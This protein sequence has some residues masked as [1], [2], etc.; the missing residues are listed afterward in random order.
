MNIPTGNVTFLF[1]DVEGSAK[2][3][4]ANPAAIQNALNRHREIFLRGIK[5]HN[6]FVFEKPGDAFCCA[7]ENT[8]DAVNASIDIQRDLANENWDD[9]KIQIKIGIHTGSAEWDGNKYSGYI[10]M[11]RT[12]RVMSAAYGGQVIVSDNAYE[13][14]KDKFESESKSLVSFRDLGV[15]R[16]KDVIQPIRL[17]Q[18]IS[19]GLREDFPPLKTLDA[20][21]NNLPVQ[22]TSFIGREKEMAAVK[23]L[24]SAARLLTLLGPGGTGKTRLSLQLAADMIDEFENG[25][26]IVEL[27]S[28]SDPALLVQAIADTLGLK[29]QTGMLLEKI[30]TDHL[31]SKE[32]LLVLD[33]CEHIINSCAELTEELLK[34]CP[35]L[36]IITTSRTVLRSEDETIYKVLPLDHPDPKKIKTHEELADYEAVR[37]FIERAVAVNPLFRI[38]ES[39]HLSIAQICYQL[40]GIP[41]A[42]ELAAVRVKVLSPENICKRLEDRFRLLTGGKRTALPRQQTLRAMLDW[43]YDLLSEKEKILWRRLSVFAGGWTAEAAEEICSDE[44]IEKS[45]VGSLLNDLAGKSII[46]LQGIDNKF[47]MLQTVMQYGGVLLSE[48]GEKDKFHNKHL[49]YYMNLCEGSIPEYS[50]P[51]AKLWL[52]RIEEFYPNVQSALGWSVEHELKEKGNRLAVSMGKFWELR[53]YYTEGRSWFDKLLTSKENLPPEI[54]AN[55]KSIAAIL[56]T[57]QGKYEVSDKFILEALEI[58]ERSGNKNR[59]ANSLNNLGLNAY[60]KGKYDE[61]KKHLNECLRIRK[62]SD[63]KIGICST[64]NSLGLVDLVEGD[65]VGAKKKFVDSLEIALELNDL[66][67]TGIAYSNLAQTYDFLGESEKTK[68]YFEKGLLI[69]REL[70]NKNGICVSLYNLGVIELN[71]QKYSDAKKLFEESK[72]IC[73]ETGYLLGELYALSGI[74]LVTFAE[75]DIFNAENIFKEVLRLQKGFIDLQCTAAGMMLIA[76]I[77]NND[78]KNELAAKLV[79]ACKTRYET[80]GA[81]FEKKMQDQYEIILKSV[82][83]AIGEERTAIAVEEGRTMGLDKAIEIAL[84]S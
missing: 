40:D 67:Y 43:S 76:E 3:S 35:G 81:F 72:A 5:S 30:L 79:S 37:L 64:L 32:L 77:K 84:N 58:Y 13:A 42:I 51:T 14:S 20:R 78:G 59:V 83:E 29:E 62:D 69:D 18:V 17:F 22:L 11:A 68:E 12:A 70:G 1:S 49:E 33:N 8:A 80:T 44:K 31:K 21:P 19:D 47:R 57:Q 75:K 15:R 10:T 56:A 38:N 52:N 48:S 39:N 60:D 23:K 34:N 55:S 6:G 16:L 46:L 50:G 4:Q 27:A 45:D 65:Y 41:L 9:T 36:K 53:G 82:K 25:V 63:N 7:F 73:M 54:I 28:L 2:L 74:G 26:W 61:A 66:M 24:F 71:D